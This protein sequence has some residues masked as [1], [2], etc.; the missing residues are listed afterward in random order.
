MT[1]LN[2]VF[3]RISIINLPERIDRRQEMAEELAKI[4]L[5]LNSDGIVIFPAIRPSDAGDFPSVGARGAYL[6]HLEVLRNARDSGIKRLLV[7]EDDLMFDARL[8]SSLKMLSE[9]INSEAWDFL[10]LGHMQDGMLPIHV[11]TSQSPQ[12]CLHFYA[13]QARV[14]N[15]L[16]SYLEECL[17]RSAGHPEG[18]SMHVDGAI[19]M[20][21]ERHP[22]F[23]T[24]LIQPSM[25]RQRP[26]RSDITNNRWYDKSA[27]LSP[28]MRL[29]RKFKKKL[30]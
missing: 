7:L 6:S 8:E 12:Q 15:E 9:K 19:S 2:D 28:M 14:F 26:S 24:W 17:K 10:Y 21:R 1:R 4:G 27:I 16:I 18:G 29:L 22:Q 25:G 11:E 30:I 3:D 13:V 5:S 20:F 23:I